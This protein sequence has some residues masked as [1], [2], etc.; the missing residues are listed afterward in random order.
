MKNDR[1]FE[2]MNK[3]QNSSDGKNTEQKKIEKEK[4]YKRCPNIINFKKN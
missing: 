4:R 2:I 1:R 3:I